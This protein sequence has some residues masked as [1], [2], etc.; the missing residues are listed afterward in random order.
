MS[1]VGPAR[2]HSWTSSLYAPD[3]GSMR[4]EKRQESL[5]TIKLS[6]QV[7]VILISF[8]AGSTGTC[9]IYCA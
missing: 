3:D 9:D 7:R 8:K 6:P 2:V 5:D 4:N 1:A